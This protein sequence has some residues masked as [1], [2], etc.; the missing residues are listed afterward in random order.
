MIIK[1][2]LFLC[3]ISMFLMTAILYGQNIEKLAKKCDEGDIK[4]CE[5]IIKIAK[6]HKKW[7]VR[8]AAVEKLNDQSVLTEIAK[9][10]ESPSVRQ[11]AVECLNDQSVLTEIAKKDEYSDVRQAAVQG[12]DDQSVLFEIANE[13]ESQY[14]RLAAVECLDD[15]SI[16]SKIAKTNKYEN[17]AESALKKVTDQQLLAEIVEPVMY[18]RTEG[19][20]QNTVTVVVT[21]LDVIRKEAIEM[22]KDEVLIAELSKIKLGMDFKE[23]GKFELNGIPIHNFRD[24]A[25][26][27]LKNEKLLTEL[28]DTTSDIRVQMFAIISLA[29]GSDWHELTFI[30][31]KGFDQG[32]KR[33]NARIARLANPDPDIRKY[34]VEDIDNEDI[35]KLIAI[36]DR[37]QIVREAAKKRL[38]EI[39]K[40]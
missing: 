30:Q 4:A 29:L 33:R 27:K 8:K 35:L 25:V 9:K 18:V 3:L 13:D 32:Q 6:T 17:V 34:I 20:S 40:K 38:K 7:D 36:K 12:L 37:M 1:K 15:Q 26:L 16:L 31:G 39:R 28:A 24:L 2:S 14:V 11:A 23:Y 21:Q 19:D 10:D 22:L 5:K